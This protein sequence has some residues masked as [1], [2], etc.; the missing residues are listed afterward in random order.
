M[1]APITRLLD[2]LRAELDKQDEGQ[3]F[4]PEPF[5]RHV[6]ATVQGSEERMRRETFRS[7]AG[8]YYESNEADR[9]RR[10]IL[11]AFDAGWAERRD[12]IIEQITRLARRRAGAGS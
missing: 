9:R 4:D 10:V 1:N 11:A 5:I 6:T 2:E 3:A 7:Y 12:R 8:G